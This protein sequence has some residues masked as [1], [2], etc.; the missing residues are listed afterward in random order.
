M[1]PNRTSKTD[2]TEKNIE[3]KGKIGILTG[4]RNILQK[5]TSGECI[6]LEFN[7]W[8]T[9]KTNINISSKH[10]TT[11]RNG[12]LSCACIAIISWNVSITRC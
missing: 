12:H 11:M 5:S 1:R 8:N 7:Q 4:T 2:A 9:F 6:V 10:L 3:I